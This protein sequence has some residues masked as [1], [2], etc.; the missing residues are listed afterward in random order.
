L[1]FTRLYYLPGSSRVKGVLISG[2]VSPFRRIRNGK[3][4]PQVKKSLPP[5]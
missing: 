2:V 4:L 1:R 5:L 3:L